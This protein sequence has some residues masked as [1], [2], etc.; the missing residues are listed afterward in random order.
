M[1]DL[2]MGDRVVA[3]AMRWVGTPYRHQGANR[4]A[5]ADCLGLVR[6]IW[7]A[8]Y[9]GEPGPVPPYRADWRDAGIG[10]ALEVAARRYLV[11]QA[12]AARA[13]DVVLF[14]LMRHR[15]ARHCGVMVSAE[16]FVHAQEHLGVVEMAMSESWARRVA[17]VFRFP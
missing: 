4:G 14:R 5:G 10:D 17:G 7:G 1:T 8:L 11:E 13:G 9:G 3:E 12:G 15:P 6:G 16:R 2:S